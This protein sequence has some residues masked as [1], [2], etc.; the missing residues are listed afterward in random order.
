MLALAQY[1]RGIHRCG[2][3]DSIRH[4]PD[5]VF[6]PDRD[7]CPLCAEL[8]RQDRIHAESDKRFEKQLGEEPDPREKRPADG[9]TLSLRPATADEVIARAR[10]MAAENKKPGKG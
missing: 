5:N 9:R 7:D 4:D 1:R 2:V 8:E 3:H 10:R 6:V